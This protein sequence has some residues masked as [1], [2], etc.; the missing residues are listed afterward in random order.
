MLYRHCDTGRFTCSLFA[1]FFPHMPASLACR[2][3]PGWS[4]C[5]LDS[6]ALPDSILCAKAMGESVVVSVGTKD[7]HP[8]TKPRPV[9]GHRMG[10]KHQ[11][12]I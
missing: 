8:P 9:P 2:R 1:N 10:V 3:V 12:Q 11:V 7:I 5:R 6:I 4:H